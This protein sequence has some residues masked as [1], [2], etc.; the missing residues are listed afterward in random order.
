MQGNKEKKVTVIQ[1]RSNGYTTHFCNGCSFACPS[2]TTGE[3]II[4]LDM[5]FRSNIAGEPFKATIGEDGGRQAEPHKTMMAEE[6]LV[7]IAMSKDDLIRLADLILANFGEDEKP[8]G[9]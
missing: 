8:K 4:V 5:L 3:T 7:G 6:V 9:E 1:R 2:E